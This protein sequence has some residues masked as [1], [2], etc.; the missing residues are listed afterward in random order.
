M[1]FLDLSVFKT[2]VSFSKVVHI[3][4]DTKYS[5]NVSDLFL[6]QHQ[7]SATGSA[8]DGITFVDSLS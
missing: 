6:I 8:S 7:Y 2:E 5:F 1:S 4:G 3:F